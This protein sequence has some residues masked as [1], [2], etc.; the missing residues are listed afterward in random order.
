VKVIHLGEDPI[1]TS[2]P[3]W[4]FP[5]YLALEANPAA[6]LRLLSSQ[7]AKLKSDD[8]RATEWIERRRQQHG[9]ALRARRERW[10]RFADSER[11]KPQS[12]FAWVSRC[13]GRAKDR[14]TVIV[15]EYDL[16]LPFVEFTEPGSYVGFS[17]SGGLGFG[18]GG[19][20]GYKLGRPDATVVS[21][22]GDGTYLLGVPSACHLM[23]AMH[24]RLPVLWVVCNNAGWG[25]L[26][27]ETM[28]VHPPKP[29]GSGHSTPG[30]DFPML[31][32]R[33]RS[34]LET[35]VWPSYERVC[36]AFGGYGE[37]VRTPGELPDALQRALRVV[38]DEGRQALLNVDCTGDPPVFNPRRTDSHAEVHS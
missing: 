25:Y 23:S 20:L 17:S 3:I 18:M 19:A 29:L 7:L 21:V 16:Q 15:Q 5:A 12:T 28:R 14:N 13:L 27:L 31:G 33:Q 35:D 4:S 34:G 32:F 38:R 24:R 1:H 22:V 9:A 30:G 6:T 2:T 37:A 11:Q 36:E 10:N 26:A 8:P